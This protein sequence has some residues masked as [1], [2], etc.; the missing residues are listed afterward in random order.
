M[1]TGNPGVDGGITSWL[2]ETVLDVVEVV[3]VND[4]AGAKRDWLIAPT[5]RIRRPTA[6]ARPTRR[7][8]LRDAPSFPG[9]PFAGAGSFVPSSPEDGIT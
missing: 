2:V 3:V 9:L 1:I 4:S 8:F 5:P 6:D 7:K